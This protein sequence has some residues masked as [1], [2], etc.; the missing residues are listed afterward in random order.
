MG[1]KVDILSYFSKVLKGLLLF[2]GYLELYVLLL[3]SLIFGYFLAEIAELDIVDT[4]AV[5]SVCDGSFPGGFDLFS[6]FLLLFIMF[7][8]FK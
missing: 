1:R 4:V 3:L 5:Y 7:Y 2:L 6:L 8:N